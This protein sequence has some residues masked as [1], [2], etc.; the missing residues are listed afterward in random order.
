MWERIH[1]IALLVVCYIDSI[2][3]FYRASL[4]FQKRD[5]DTNSADP[6]YA[7]V[8]IFY[9]ATLIFVSSLYVFNRATNHLGLRA[10]ISNLT[11]G[12]IIEPSGDVESL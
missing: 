12:T 3:A 7:V 6:L 9:G 2:P 8:F 1:S 5:V 4:R 10:M 11:I